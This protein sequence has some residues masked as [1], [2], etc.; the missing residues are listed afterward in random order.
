MGESV[1]PILSI[2]ETTW[3]E[4]AIQIDEE[5]GDRCYVCGVGDEV[6]EMSDGED[7]E[8]EAVKVEEK[9]GED[10]ERF[11]A[12]KDE[13]AVKNLIDPRRPSE[14]E[15]EDHWRTHLPYRNWCEI[16]V[17]AKGK[18]EDHRKNPDKER[19]LSEY[20]W[21]YCFPGDELGCKLVVLAGRE[22]VTGTYGATAVPMKGS[23]GYF[24]L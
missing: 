17:R 15:V 22:R 11:K 12:T 14:K 24:T 18:D 2:H 10:A 21:D 8:D 1:R 23:M 6:Q 19:G 4:Q 20:S 3:V 16:C 9:M 13:R 5:M 7:E